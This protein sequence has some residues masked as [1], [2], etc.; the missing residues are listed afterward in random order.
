MRP[1]MDRLAWHAGAGVTP[2]QVCGTP[3]PS[4]EG[5]SLGDE[6][7]ILVFRFP[8]NTDCLLNCLSAIV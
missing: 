6:S 7:T 8:G 1:G 3:R 2:D 5:K 4:Q